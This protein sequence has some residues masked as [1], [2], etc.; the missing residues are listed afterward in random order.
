[1]TLERSSAV[2]PDTKGIGN[3]DSYNLQFLNLE[4]RN[5][6]DK[7]CYRVTMMKTSIPFLQQDILNQSH[8][9]KSLLFTSRIQS[10]YFTKVE[11]HYL[12]D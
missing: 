7:F 12:S 2:I 5:T 3:C 4:L 8:F 11:P 1:M 6:L 10:I 9:Y